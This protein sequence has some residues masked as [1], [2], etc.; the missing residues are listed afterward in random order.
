MPWDE[1]HTTWTGG[2]YE[3]PLSPEELAKQAYYQSPAY[4]RTLPKSVRDFLGSLPKGVAARAIGGDAGR[5]ESLPN[6]AGTGRDYFVTYDRNLPP[7]KVPLVQAHEIAHGIDELA[8]RIDTSGL[9]GELQTVYHDLNNPNPSPTAK[10]WTPQAAGYKGADVDREYI[11][12][13]VRA[14][15]TDPN[16]MKTVAPNTAAVIRNAVNSN[17]L[18]NGT[19]QFNS[20]APLLLTAGGSGL[21]LAALLRADGT[22]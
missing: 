1:S 19:L 8:G 2:Q 3:R 16:Y 13:A 18:I 6:A 20:L 11:A 22:E 5:F 9:K 14:Y 21:G 12:E 15:M 4:W 7:A 10:Q 17:S